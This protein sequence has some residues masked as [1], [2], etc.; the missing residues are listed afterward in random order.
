MPANDEHGRRGTLSCGT[1]LTLSAAG[2]IGT[3]RA[4]FTQTSPIAHDPQVPLT[5]AGRVARE[6]ERDGGT[7]VKDYSINPCGNFQ[8]LKLSVRGA[9]CEWRPGSYL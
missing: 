3:H 4:R 5:V 2:A 8:V 1:P 9:E 7:G 6:C